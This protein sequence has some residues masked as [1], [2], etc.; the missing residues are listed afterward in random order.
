MD[1]LGR[2]AVFVGYIKIYRI[3]DLESVLYPH[4][5][6]VF[7]AG[8]NPTS[9]PTDYLC[10]IIKHVRKRFPRVERVSCYSKALDIV[11]KT[12]EELINLAKAGLDI[13][14]MGLESGSKKILRIM[15]KGTN[16]AT[17]IKVGRRLLKAGI[18]LSLYIILGLGGYELSEEHVKE[19]ARVLTAINPTIFRF[20]TFNVGQESL[21]RDDINSGKLTLLKPVDTLKEEKGIIQLLGDNVTSEVYNDHYANYFPGHSKNIKKDKEWFI[22]SLN[23]LIDNPEIQKLEPRTLLHM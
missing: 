10:K 12:D 11:R 6:W 9:A 14:Y 2:I 1:V 3:I 23:E 4:H 22:K 8:G 15:K 19:T 7:L 13:V 5:K 20:R 16:D 17:I 18:K 21:I